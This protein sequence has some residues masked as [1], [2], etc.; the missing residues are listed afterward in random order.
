MSVRGLQLVVGKAV[1]N[2]D[3][4]VAILNE[5]RADVIRGLE[6]APHEVEQL[7]AIRASTLAEFAAQ[8]EE[9]ARRS[10][11]DERSRLATLRVGARRQS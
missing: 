5:C 4:R 10:E 7:M 3:F 6:L 11:R 1:I 9:I 8:V 2:Q